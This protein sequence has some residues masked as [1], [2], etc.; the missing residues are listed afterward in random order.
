MAE[1]AAMDDLV[2]LEEVVISNSYEITALFHILERKGLVTREEM[3][4]EVQRLKEQTI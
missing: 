1:K 3:L 2:S 4:A